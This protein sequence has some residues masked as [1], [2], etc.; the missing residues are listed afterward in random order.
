LKLR[1]L[2]LDAD[3]MIQCACF[4]L[5]ESYLCLL[6]NRNIRLSISGRWMA[7]TCRAFASTWGLAQF[8]DFRAGNITLFSYQ[9]SSTCDSQSHRH[10]PC[11]RLT[12][13]LPFLLASA[14]REDILYWKGG[15]S[16]SLVDTLRSSQLNVFS[17]TSSLSS[18]PAKQT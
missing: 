3:A 15:T 4:R 2:I 17:H 11:G 13:C 16:S 7:Q 10:A 18:P 8:T 9:E 12:H 6:F 14:I 1:Y 5:S